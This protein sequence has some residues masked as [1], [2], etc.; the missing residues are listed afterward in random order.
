MTGMIRTVLISAVWLL[1]TA[2]FFIFTK[3]HFALLFAIG[4]VL[5]WAWLLLSVHLVKRKIDCQLIAANELYKTEQLGYQLRV[6]NTSRLS[7]TQL[8]IHLAIEH[9]FTGRRE[10]RHHVLSIPANRTEEFAFRLPQHYIGHVTLEIE[11]LTIMDSF[12]FFRLVQKQAA[13]AG[14]LIMPNPYFLKLQRIE[15]NRHVLQTPGTI[16]MKKMD[17]EE[18]ADLS[19][20]QPGDPVKKIHWKLSTKVDEL[21]VKRHETLTG[22]ATVMTIDFTSFTNCVERYDEFI[23]TVSALLYSHVADNREVRF[24]LDHSTGKQ[25]MINSE[26]DAANAIK[27]VLTKQAADMSLSTEQWKILRNTYPHCIVLTTNPARRTEY[28]TV[29]IADEKE[30]SAV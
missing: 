21:F 22:D 13:Q 12:A 30:G 8:H 5:L 6:Q 3:T 20:Y 4:S 24:I 19:V 23:E 17:G 18:L 1:F 28:Q 11:K 26:R 9:V 7:V 10:S 15:Q 14:M 2:I 29:V 27:E 16:P 25:V